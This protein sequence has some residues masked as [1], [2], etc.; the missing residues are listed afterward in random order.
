[1]ET[2]STK[3]FSFSELAN[4]FLS[5]KKVRCR[6]TT[7]DG[8]EILLKT[9]ILPFFS[10]YKLSEIKP[11]T[12]RTWQNELLSKG[13][14]NRYIRRIDTLLVSIFNYGV[15]FFELPNNPASL[16][17]PI[18]INPDKIVNF[19]T[20][21]DFNH[22]ISHIKDPCL[23]L[24]FNTLYWTGM[25]IGELLAL[26]SNDV[27]Y[28]EG[29]ISVSKTLHK[30]KRKLVIT[31]PK[32]KKGRRDIYIHD[33]LLKEIQ[34][35]IKSNQLDIV[36]SDSIN[37]S[38]LE[39]FDASNYKRLFPYS[40][41]YIRYHMYKYTKKSKLS[42]I[43]VH[44][45]RH[46]HASLLI[47]LN[48]SPLLISERLGHEKVETTLSIYSHLYPNKQKQLTQLLENTCTNINLTSN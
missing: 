7:Y 40:A 20:L 26:S 36:S 21:Q 29:F 33:V 24:A 41:E 9:H 45:L 43:R 11:F 48:V 46:S 37:V 42:N 28:A 25:R 30:S 6:E 18:G 47:E 12:V 3:S 22:F 4:S 1:M 5:E 27:N 44:D 23:H 17:G 13:L 2:Q 19:W 14:K 8:Y 38:G 34:T 39:S 10:N 16:A 32:T 15:R 31:P 35:Y